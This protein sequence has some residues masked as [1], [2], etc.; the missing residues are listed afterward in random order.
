MLGKPVLLN[1]KEVL[2]A[3]TTHKDK[4]RH[5]KPDMTKGS[6]KLFNPLQRP[7]KIGLPVRRLKKS[8]R[9]TVQP[10]LGWVPRQWMCLPN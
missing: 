4:E 9:K 10:K 6:R 5:V 8:N 1:Q 2:D 3:L 7:S